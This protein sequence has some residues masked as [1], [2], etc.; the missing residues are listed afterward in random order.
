MEQATRTAKQQ[1]LQRASFLGAAAVSFSFSTS[2]ST[3]LAAAA[4]ALRSSATSCSSV[5]RA[6]S[7]TRHFKRKESRMIHRS[8]LT[9]ARPSPAAAPPLSRASERRRGE[10]LGSRHFPR[11]RGNGFRELLLRTC[12]RRD[13]SCMQQ[14][15]RLL[16]LC[17]TK[18]RQQT[19]MSRARYL[20]A[21]FLQR[22]SVPNKCLIS[23]VPVEL[24]FKNRARCLA[25]F[26]FFS[27][28]FR[29]QTNGQFH[30]FPSN[31]FSEPFEVPGGIL[32]FSY[33]FR[34]QTR[35]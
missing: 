12:K 19:N 3:F 1:S 27:Y 28:G 18:V 24:V 17:S 6:T 10:V 16:W 5:G 4:S 21:F 35:G 2:C 13:S 8:T 33:G 34:Y 22:I 30:V 26:S 25:A 23:N 7:Q 32:F 20:A 15:L 31:R 9:V 14:S 11:V 29:F